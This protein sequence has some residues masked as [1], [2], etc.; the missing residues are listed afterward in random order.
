[1]KNGLI[2]NEKE[3]WNQHEKFKKELKTLMKTFRIN[4]NREP[5]LNLFLNA[6]KIGL[7]SHEDVNKW[8]KQM[9]LR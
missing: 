2:D 6:E 9:K 5:I 4:K 3:Y 8:L 1:M 7:F